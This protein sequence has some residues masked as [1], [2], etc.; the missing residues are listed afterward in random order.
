MI[1]KAIKLLIRIIALPLFSAIALFYSLILWLL[2]SYNFLLYGGEAIA[3]TTRSK[4]KTIAEIYGK[5]DDLLNTEKGDVSPQS[6]S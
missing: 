4:P 3:Y 2:F 1:I 5:L 6:N